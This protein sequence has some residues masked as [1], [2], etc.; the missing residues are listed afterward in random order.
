M[1]TAAILTLG[2]K[3]NLADSDQIARGL[4]A[5]GYNVVDTLC[6]ADAVVINTCSVTHVADQKSR[7]LIRSARR[8]SPNATIAVTGCYPRSAGAE[9]MAA[10]GADLVVGA[11]TA[12]KE[13]LLALLSAGRPG[14][15]D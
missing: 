9:A 13:R 4:S 5:S 3:L 11:N 7:R 2:C 1:P 12:E 10:L 6:E 15:T 8:L 14:A